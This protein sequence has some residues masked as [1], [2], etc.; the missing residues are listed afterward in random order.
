MISKGQLGFQDFVW[1]DGYKGWVLITEDESFKG[2]VAFWGQEEPKLPDVP[3]VSIQT[4]SENV[5]LKIDELE[6]IA[7]ADV[8]EIID[9]S[10]V[11]DQAHS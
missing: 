10:S 7:G 3:S 2:K 1:T 9:R 6:P 11:D 5:E 8:D 4:P